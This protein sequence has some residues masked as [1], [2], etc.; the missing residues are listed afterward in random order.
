MNS[1]SCKLGHVCGMECGHFG[2]CQGANTCDVQVKM[3]CRCGISIS[4]SCCKL[5][6]YGL[7]VIERIDSLSVR[8]DCTQSRFAPCI[9]RHRC[10]SIRSLL[11]QAT[12]TGVDGIRGI[13]MLVFCN[14]P[15]G[16]SRREIAEFIFAQQIRTK[17][18]LCDQPYTSGTV[19][20]HMSFRDD[21]PVQKGCRDIVVLFEEILGS[22]GAERVLCG[23]ESLILSFSVA[24]K[25]TSYSSAGS[26]RK[27][28]VEEEEGET[29]EMPLNSFE[30]L[31]LGEPEVEQDEVEEDSSEMMDETPTISIREQIAII[32][33]GKVRVDVKLEKTIERIERYLPFLYH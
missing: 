2:D 14:V 23:R 13:D 9:L 20:K 25:E 11:K 26:S 33:A 4:I 10:V 21:I 12:R 27:V 29:V 24:V 1:T 30:L 31:N 18:S 3:N 5:D 17:F 19:A 7:R 6:A 15:Y 8:V 22:K 28:L 16:I 32:K